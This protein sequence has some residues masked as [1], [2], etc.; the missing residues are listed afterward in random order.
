MAY[1]VHRPRGRWEL[2]RSVATAAGPRS[3][4]LLTFGELSEDG[5]AHAIERSGG[6]LTAEEAREAALR[7]GAPVALEPSLRAASTLLR[8]LARGATLP[9]AWSRALVETLEGR[10]ATDAA[11]SIG[12]WAEAS[13]QDR[14]AALRDLL[15]LTDAIPV[16]DRGEELRFPGF[17]TRRP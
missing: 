1:V 7:A 4:T 15:L 12:E 6:E 8:E 13:A 11:E 2:R 3:E 5:I 9:V 10:S 17:S 14:G 16:R